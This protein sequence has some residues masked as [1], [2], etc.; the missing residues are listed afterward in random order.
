[1]LF[2]VNPICRCH[3]EAPDGV[4]RLQYREANGGVVVTARHTVIASSE[5]GEKKEFF[6]CDT[7]VKAVAM[8][9]SLD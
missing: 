9:N 8:V 2:C 4:D 6:F 3:V 5:P 1:M 7:C